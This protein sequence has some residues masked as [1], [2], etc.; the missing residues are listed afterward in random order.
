VTR[1]ATGSRTEAK[2]TGAS[3]VAWVRA[4]LAH[5]VW[6]LC[7][8]A[9]L[10]LSVGALLVALGANKDNA[11]VDFVLQAADA[12]DLG[13]F[14][15]EDGIKQFTGE[16]AG[17]KNALVNWGLGALAWLVVGRVLDRILRP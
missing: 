9:A 7:A 15:R 5:V 11:L 8:L 6:L 14:S 17:V 10:L 12:V 3:R 4:R 13:V 1:D 2:G 16:G